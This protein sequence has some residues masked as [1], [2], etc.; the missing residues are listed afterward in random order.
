MQDVCLFTTP[1]KIQSLVLPSAV[2]DRMDI[3]GAAETGSGKTLAFIIPLICRLLELK[4]SGDE[5]G[6][7][8]LILA[9]TRELALQ[10]KKQLDIFLN[11]SLVGGLS[12]QKQERLLTNHPDVIVATPGRFWALMRLKSVDS[13]LSNWSQLRVVV[14]D[15]TDRM[16][17][18]GH[19]EELQH[20][21][22]QAPKKHQTLIF[23]AT[24]TFVHQPP[25]R[26][27]MQVLTPTAKDKLS[28]L[29]GSV[30]DASV[31]YFLIRHPGRTLIFTNSID[32]SSR[33]HSILKKV[34]S[35]R[36]IL[37]LNAK[38][39]QR[40]RLINLEKFAESEDAVLIATDV[41]ARGLDIPNIQHVLHYQVSKTVESYV[42]RSG[43]TARVSQKGLT[44][45]IVDPK[46]VQFYARICQNLYR[47]EDFP[48]FPMDRPDLMDAVKERI[49]AATAVESIEFRIS[50]VCV[51]LFL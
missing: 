9:P 35:N 36:I 24:L 10:I 34:L 33:L 31:L 21:L 23:S 14:V 48:I 45:I 40:K 20:I 49:K 15:E 44:V 29:N 2:R 28:E 12:Q 18:K 25:K 27:G 1:T 30:N 17:E 5:E 13:Y 16:M 51:V 7:K 8:G 3:L 50:K 46:D 43:R 41:A 26:L 42:H 38:M 11:A 22:E 32:A 6:F 19:F 37:R 4:S 39:L 47:K